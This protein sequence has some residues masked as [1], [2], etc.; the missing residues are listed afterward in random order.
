MRTFAYKTAVRRLEEEFLL[1]RGKKPRR[2]SHKKAK[3]AMAK[4]FIV[5][6]CTNSRD[7]SGI[8]KDLKVSFEFIINNEAGH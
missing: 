1:R 2:F 3:K 4:E 8:P 5:F 6:L 7:A